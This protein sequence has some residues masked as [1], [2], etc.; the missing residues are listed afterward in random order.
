MQRGFP[1]EANLPRAKAGDNDEPHHEDRAE[2]DADARRALE[3]N[4]EQS[5]EKRNSDW[6]DDGTQC[7]RGDLKTLHGGDDADRRRY[8]RI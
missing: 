7:W 4:G 3:L 2:Y 6:D 5:A 1:A 8:Q